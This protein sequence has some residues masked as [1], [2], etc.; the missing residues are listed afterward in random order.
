MT[1]ETKEQADKI[2]YHTKDVTIPV[3]GFILKK[4][5]YWLCEDGDPTR[6]LFVWKTAQCNSDR[7]ISEWA[8]KNTYKAHN[9]IQIVCIE[10][11]YVPQVD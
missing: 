2:K 3:D 11:A 7:R 5:K 10:F 8:L 9:N 6:A 4:G 1:E